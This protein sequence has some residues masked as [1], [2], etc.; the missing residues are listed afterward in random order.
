MLKFILSDAE[1]D[2]ETTDLS[3]AAENCLLNAG[4]NMEEIGVFLNRIAK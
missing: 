2:L 3:E 1:A 4:M